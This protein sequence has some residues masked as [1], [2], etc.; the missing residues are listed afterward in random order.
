M[1]CIVSQPTEP[2]SEQL[3]ALNEE[4]ELRELLVARIEAVAKTG[5]L[6]IGRADNFGPMLYQWQKVRGCATLQDYFEE[7][8]KGQPRVAEELLRL[9][10]DA[11]RSPAIDQGRV[12][13]AKQYIRPL[14]LIAA[15]EWCGLLESDRNDF[16]SKA[17]REFVA[18]IHAESEQIA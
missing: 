1:E 7:L 10:G 12:A 16:L 5:Q 11:S 17:A 13:T 9:F 15:F 4:D 2:S 6:I 8:L 18:I 3:L 14:D